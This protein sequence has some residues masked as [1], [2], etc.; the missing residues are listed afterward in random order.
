MRPFHSFQIILINLQLGLAQDDIE[1]E[2]LAI[3]QMYSKKIC[4]ER[5]N[6]GRVFMV[7]N[8]DLSNIEM[9]LI[10]MTYKQINRLTLNKQI[11]KSSFV[12]LL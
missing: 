3:T 9:K 11:M 1:T 2:R 6:N 10:C 8:K 4:L 5:A 12:T 7:F